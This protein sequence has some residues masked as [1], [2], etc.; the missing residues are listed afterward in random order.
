MAKHK[1]LK[2]DKFIDTIG[3]VAK[4]VVKEKEKAFWVGLGLLVVIVLMIYLSSQRKGENPQA[5][6]MYLEGMGMFQSGQVQQAENQFANIARQFPRTNPGR[7]SIYYLG[8]IY[9]MTKRYDEAIQNF[10]RFLSKAKKDFI[11]T[12]SAQMGIAASKEGLKDYPGALGEYEILLKKYPDSPLSPQARLG[13]GRVKGTLGDYEGAK[14]YLEQVIADK[15]AGDLAEEAK[16][17]LGY[18][19]PK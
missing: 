5:N 16:F 6:L 10:Q 4:L 8:Y 1:E 11:L 14:Q 17:Y 18:L 12:P 9:Y 19:A 13:A 15:T 7:R 3:A 2:S